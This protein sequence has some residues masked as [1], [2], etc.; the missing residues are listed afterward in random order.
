MPQ[1]NYLNYVRPLDA[2]KV[3]LFTG[4]SNP[5]LAKDVAYHLKIDIANAKTAFYGDFCEEVRLL[6]P[7]EGKTVFILQS[8]IGGKYQ[9]AHYQ[10][11]LCCLI[12]AALRGGAKEI[13]A[14]TPYF[15]YCR[16]E[17]KTKSGQPI[18]AAIA[19]KQLFDAGA[20]RF[21]TIDIHNPTMAGF[22]HCPFDNL[23]AWP[24]FIPELF[25]KNGKDLTIAAPDAG[26]VATVLK[27]AAFYHL[28]FAIINKVR[29]PITGKVK[30]VGFVG[31]VTSKNV[32]LV[33]DEFNTCS[34]LNVGI[35]E[36][37]S[38]HPKKIIAAATHGIFARD[39]FK[40][41]DNLEKLDCVITL[42][43]VARRTD[44]SEKVTYISAAPLLAAAISRIFHHEPMEVLFPEVK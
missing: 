31:D 26:A 33:D 13:V 18:A 35:D 28:P 37:E 6:E 27:I 44:K 5:V 43:T 40:I 20:K 42:D 16:E 3:A 7:V 21:L 36:I 1:I 30:V 15:P 19:V 10:M 11:E 9:T 25:K 23:F 2:A 38:H 41:I 14:V 12:D 32:L 34:T 24:I 17:R 39:A 4:S 22:V 29:D 8:G